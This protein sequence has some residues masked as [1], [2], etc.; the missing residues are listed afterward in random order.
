MF[1]VPMDQPGVEV[2]GVYTLSGERTNITFYN[3]VRVRDRWRI[4]DVDGGWGVMMGI[5]PGR[6]LR[7]VRPALA[8]LLGARPRR[9]PASPPTSTAGRGST[10]P[11]SASGWRGAPTEVRWPLAPA[12]LA[13]GWSRRVEVPEAE[14]P[15]RSCSAPRRSSARRGAVSRWSAPTRCA[16]TST[17]RRRWRPHRAPAAVLARHD[18]LRRHQRDAAQHHRQRGLGLPR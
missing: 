17:R 15:W 18:H 13:R 3:D 9:G 6:A 8:R 1:L 4:G 10:I 11:T 7:R 16:A 5:A 12:P 2:Q 14:G